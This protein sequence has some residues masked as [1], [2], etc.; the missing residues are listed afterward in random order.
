MPA[1]TL[2]GEGTEKW[3]LNSNPNSCPPYIMSADG[4]RKVQTTLSAGSSAGSFACHRRDLTR[5]TDELGKMESTRLLVTSSKG[6]SL[7]DIHTSWITFTIKLSDDRELK[8]VAR[9]MDN[10]QSSLHSVPSQADHG[11]PSY[12]V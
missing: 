12:P 2:S 9:D 7:C 1:R 8:M 5:V 10:G 11:R 4:Q 6:Q 3:Y